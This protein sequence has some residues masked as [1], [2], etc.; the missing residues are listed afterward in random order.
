MPMGGFS[1]L[2]PPTS[3]NPLDNVTKNLSKCLTVQIGNT[4]SWEEVWDITK[5]AVTL[6]VTSTYTISE[7]I[8]HPEY[9]YYIL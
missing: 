2:I 5:P 7:G 8:E 1:R 4:S 6:L 9:P 3:H